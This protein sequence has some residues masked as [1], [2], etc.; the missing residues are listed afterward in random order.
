MNRRSFKNLCLLDIA[1][2]LQDGL[3][4]FSGFSRVA[5]I[6]CEKPDSPM[7][8]YDPQNLLAGH[9]PKFKELYLDSDTWRREIPGLGL[10]GSSGH[11][12]TEKNLQLAGLISCGARSNSIFYQMWFTEHHPNMCSIGPTERWLEHAA[13]RLSHDYSDQN[14]LYSDI[15][16]R[17]L[18]E[19]ATHAIRDFFVDE[20]NLLLG[21]DS[22]LRIYPILD[23]VLSISS[24]RE[25]GT[26]PRGEL[27][28]VEPGMMDQIRFMGRFA[29]EDQPELAHHKHVRKLLMSVENSHRKLV[30]DGKT[31]VG[32]TCQEVPVFSICAEHKRGYGFLKMNDEPICSFSNGG[33]HSTAYREKLVQVEEFILESNLD[34]ETRVQLFKIVSALVHFSQENQFGGTFV[35]DLSSPPLKI[36]G[37]KFDYPLDLREPDALNLT[38]ALARVDGAIHIGADLYLHGFACLLDGHAIPGE[39]R[40]RG[41]RFNSALRFTA[42]HKNLLVVVVSSDWPV[43]IMQRGVELNALCEWKPLPGNIIQPPTLEDWVNRKGFDGGDPSWRR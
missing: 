13:T 22:Q 4:H 21:W 37:Q 32:V 14:T 17:F 24:T 5:L 33:F 43:S 19:Y 16:G 9:E 31:I 11:I 28:F 27:I 35:V 6:Y 39:D 18:R 34:T 25:E 38:Q 26:W 42:E 8:V 20:I 30:S 41:A 23:A 3:S 7:H 15:S 10:M 29:R 36:P 1:D 40:S 12:S 2:G